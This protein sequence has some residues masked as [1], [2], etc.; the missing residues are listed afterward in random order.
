MFGIKAA[1]EERAITSLPW[2]VWAGDEAGPTWSGKAVTTSTAMQLLT[3]YGCSD[4]IGEGISTLPIDVFRDRGADG[5]EEVKKPGWLDE[6]APD[7]GF[8]DWCSQVLN[9]L[10]LGGNAF[11][12]LEYGDG[13][14]LREAVPLDPDVCSV[15]RERGR[16]V[17]Y[18]N[19]VPAAPQSVLHIKGPMLPGRDVGMS[20]I[21]YARQTIGKGLAVEEFSARFFGQGMNLSGVIEDP[22]PPDSEKARM[23][24]RVW[25]R[26]HSGNS[27]SH[28]P[29]VLQ[30]GATWKPTGV[31]N[32]QAQFLQTQQ[33]TAAQICSFLFRI[34]PSEFGL[35]MSAGGSI[36]Y[37]NIEQRNVRKLQVTFLPWIVRIEQAL[38]SLLA[39]PRYVKFNVDGLLRGDTKSRF[40]TYEVA[41]RINTAA[42]AIGDKPIMLTSEMRDLEDMDPLA[43]EDVP[44]KPA[45]PAPPAMPAADTPS[46]PQQNALRVVTGG[47]T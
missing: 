34:D 14:S 2:G 40:D 29:G 31:T 36:T 21:E 45:A 3:V 32:E 42:V 43:P 10:V 28:L 38:S 18:V 44:V 39:K 35:S 16:K 30:G 41:S 22:G 7:L 46:D 4:F 19:G 15:R 26:L 8:I 1:S 13:M 20:P 25:A 24:A 12:R 23:M 37:A 11:C 33:F 47:T 17:I 5:S 6:P 27:K 9:S